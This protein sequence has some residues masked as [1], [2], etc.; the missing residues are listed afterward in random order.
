MA[1]TNQSTETDEQ[2]TTMTAAGYTVA[3]TAL[4]DF[5]NVS[6]NA[7]KSLIQTT[8]DGEIIYPDEVAGYR[9]QETSFKSEVVFTAPI[10]VDRSPNKRL[11]ETQYM[12]VVYSPTREDHYHV[13]VQIGESFS[14]YSGY[15]IMATEETELEAAE[16]AVEFMQTYPA[17]DV[18]HLYRPGDIDRAP[19][20]PRLIGK[21]AD[22]I[23]AGSEIHVDGLPPAQAVRELDSAETRV[24]GGT[25]WECDLIDQPTQTFHLFVEDSY[26]KPEVSY[27]GSLTD[28]KT[29]THVEHLTV[30]NEQNLRESVNEPLYQWLKDREGETVIRRKDD[31][32]F[33][34]VE[35]SELR[36]GFLNPPSDEG[37]DPNS[38]RTTGTY[39][40]DDTDADNWFDNAVELPTGTYT[41]RSNGVVEIDDTYG[42]DPVISRRVGRLWCVRTDHRR[43]RDGYDSRQPTTSRPTGP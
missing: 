7:A 39:I 32:V 11:S 19:C 26:S 42:V 29:R 3:Q 23:R 34:V 30:D 6:A 10:S 27:A 8:D 13:G 18:D 16:K 22:R 2:S 25:V 4:G 5:A 9:R 43:T 35:L 12:V 37:L 38:R 36:D 15:G 40:G 17:P 20:T 41:V 21:R 14:S 1:T 31:C 28:Y 33:A 24:M